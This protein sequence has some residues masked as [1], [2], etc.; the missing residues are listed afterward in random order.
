MLVYSPGG[1]LEVPP[2]TP[3]SGTLLIGIAKPIPVIRDMDLIRRLFYQALCTR[4]IWVSGCLG[5]GSPDTQPFCQFL[6]LVFRME[7]FA[8]TSIH[9]HF[10]SFFYYSW[11]RDQ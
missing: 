7:G 4:T 2:D 11:F 3:H 5:F 10:S 1:M 9:D 8:H 6:K